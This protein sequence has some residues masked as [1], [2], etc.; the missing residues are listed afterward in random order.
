MDTCIHVAVG[1]TKSDM[2]DNWKMLGLQQVGF[3]TL[4]KNLYTETAWPSGWKV[5]YFGII[6]ERR[7]VQRARL[8]IPLHW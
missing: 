7:Y 6:S 4:M 5:G 1:K 2:H 3:A 8:D